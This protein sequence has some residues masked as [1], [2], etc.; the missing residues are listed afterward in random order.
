MKKIQFTDHVEDGSLNNAL[1]DEF[2]HAII[3]IMNKDSVNYDK[4]MSTENKSER[5]EADTE[6]YTYINRW[7]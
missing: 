1:E 6:E 5:K 2:K 4:G 3:T 7:K